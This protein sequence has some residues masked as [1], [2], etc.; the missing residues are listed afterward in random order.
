MPKPVFYKLVDRRAVPCNDAAEWGEWFALANRRV[1][2][3]WI[4]DVRIS[5][6]FLGLDHNPFPD[7]DPALFETMAFVNGEDCHMQ[8]YFIWEEAEAGHEEMV[9][10]IRAEMAQAKIKAAAAWATVWK[11]LADA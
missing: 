9:A 10:L 6:V 8:R 1:A 5:T 11:R 7:R 2:E 3:T 4:D